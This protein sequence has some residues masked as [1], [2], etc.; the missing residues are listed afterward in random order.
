MRAAYKLA[1]ASRVYCI[2][3]PPGR[4]QREPQAGYAGLTNPKLPVAFSP[5][6]YPG[7]EMLM[8]VVRA[9]AAAII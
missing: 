9:A 5:I 1:Q 4:A 7:A 3:V 8:H 6:H 2:S